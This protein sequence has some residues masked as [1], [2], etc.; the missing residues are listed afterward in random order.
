MHD[1][2]TL[3]ITPALL[4]HLQVLLAQAQEKYPPATPQHDALA[5]LEHAC[6]T[7]AVILE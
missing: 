5:E 2:F 4:R 1:T 6:G 7:A 3:E